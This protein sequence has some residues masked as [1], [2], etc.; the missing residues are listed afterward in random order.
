MKEEQAFC[1][2]CEWTG[3]AEG[4]T[5]CPVCGA[6]LSS[7]D[8]FEEEEAVAGK[9]DKYSADLISKVQEENS[10]DE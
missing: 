7:L 5:S 10:C 6:N 9:E 8:S 1:P 4:I 2:N 3:N